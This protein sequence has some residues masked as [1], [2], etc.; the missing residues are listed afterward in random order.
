MSQL[1]KQPNPRMIKFVKENIIKLNIINPQDVLILVDVTCY[2]N[3]D[4]LKLV[5]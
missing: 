5:T 3:E 2:D 4:F 1:A